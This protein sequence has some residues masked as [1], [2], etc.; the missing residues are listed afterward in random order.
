MSSGFAQFHPVYVRMKKRFTYDSVS[1]NQSSPR[2]FLIY[3]TSPMDNVA[4]ATYGDTT[5][6]IRAAIYTKPNAS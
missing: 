6:D 5:F 4:G 2:L 3:W 1:D